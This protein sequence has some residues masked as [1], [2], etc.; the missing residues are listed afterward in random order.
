MDIRICPLLS[1]G[2]GKEQVFIY[3]LFVLLSL[4]LL[5]SH[6]N[7]VVSRFVCRGKLFT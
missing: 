3:C 7:G 2:R 4:S 1:S 5:H 6:A